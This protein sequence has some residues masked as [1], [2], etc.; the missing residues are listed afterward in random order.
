MHTEI[1]EAAVKALEAGCDLLIVPVNK[2][3]SALHAV[4]TAVD[5]GRISAQRVEESLRRIR[6]MKRKLAKPVRVVSGR[7]FRQEARELRACA[8]QLRK[9]D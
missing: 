4:R 8:R 1:G 7:T 9:N 3:G 5:S 2:S 6:A